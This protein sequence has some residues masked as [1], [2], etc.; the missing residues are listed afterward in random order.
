MNGTQL[1]DRLYAGYGKTADKIGFPYSH[2]RSDTPFDPI[3]DGNL[4]DP[5]NM[6]LSTRTRPFEVPQQ[7]KDAVFLMW[8]DGRQLQQFDFLVGSS[9]TYYI[10]DMQ[11]NLPIQAVRCNHTIK[12]ER[13]GYTTVGD[14]VQD[15]ELIASN[16]PCFTQCKRIDIKTPQFA[17]NTAGQA[18]THW[19]A[20]IPLPNFTLKQHDIVTDES[21]VQ[22]ELDSPDFT[23]MGYVCSIRLATQ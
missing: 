15:V 10:A 23:N 9:G 7:Y 13:P 11:P 20:F 17:A 19:D 8:A 6:A 5:I 4:L 12:V 14:I 3:F 2:Y 1:Q 16:I 21:G 18:I 22:Y